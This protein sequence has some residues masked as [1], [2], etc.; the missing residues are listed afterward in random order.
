MILLVLFWNGYFQDKVLLGLLI[1]QS[2]IGI[3]YLLEQKVPKRI[4]LFRLPFLLSMILAAYTLLEHFVLL[5]A[6]FVGALWFIF[7]LIY[8]FR[9]HPSLSAWATKIIECCKKW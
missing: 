5:A 7:G 4:T 6:F 2:L 1:G 3:Y 9:I 8:I